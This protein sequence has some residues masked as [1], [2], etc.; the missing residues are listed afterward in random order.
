MDTPRISNADLYREKKQRGYIVA[1]GLAVLS[2]IEYIIAVEL[3][4]PMVWL[5]PFMIAKGGLIMEYFMH[6]S[7]LRGGHAE[8]TH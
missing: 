5:I 6:F 8:G 4:R 3:E 7:A 1:F 2:V